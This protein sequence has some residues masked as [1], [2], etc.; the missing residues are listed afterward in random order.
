MDPEIEEA[1]LK[2][3]NTLMHKVSY[4]K[5]FMDY[6]NMEINTLKPFLI[7]THPHFEKSI[8]LLI[9][10][11]LSSKYAAEK[12]IVSVVP[13][14]INT[15][16]ITSEIEDEIKIFQQIYKIIE[17]LSDCIG[18][19]NNIRQTVVE[20]CLKTSIKKNPELQ[21]LGFDCLATIVKMMNEF[22]RGCMY[23]NLKVLLIELNVNKKVQNSI[24]NSLK[25][26][27]MFYPEE[28]ENA[29]LKNLSSEIFDHNALSIQKIPLYFNALSYIVDNEFFTRKVL[30]T[31][32]SSFSKNYYF[33]G[34]CIKNLKH[35]VDNEKDQKISTILFTD[36]Q[37][38]NK[39][40]EY[41]YIHLIDTDIVPENTNLIPL[42]EILE[43]VNTLLKSLIS[44]KNLDYDNIKIHIDEIIGKF[45]QTN[46]HFLFVLLNG[47]LCRLQN[48]N[49]VTDDF[50]D[51]LLE[52]V[53][54]CKEPYVH[55]YCVQLLANIINKK[56]EGNFYFY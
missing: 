10:I 22:E 26:A 21:R 15:Y 37:I 40:I 35:I 46:D 49:F 34:C 1:Y 16:L 36:F 27:C 7:P 24:F 25:V 54:C 53:F 19:N 18:D 14:M 3:L 41:F 8:N 45:K 12:I 31:I 33:Y 6:L 17:K 39:I 4:A 28:V 55:C 51:D 52:V 2:T 29:I 13:L 9:S 38:L 11:A 47:F 42:N 56:S 20:Q 50:I 23:T 5:N 48:I 32:I 30:L 44:I 43:N